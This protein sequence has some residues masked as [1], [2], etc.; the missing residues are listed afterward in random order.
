MPSSAL[1]NSLPRSGLPRRSSGSGPEGRGLS[2]RE[3]RGGLG[4]GAEGCKEQICQ[5]LKLKPT[6]SPE[7]CLPPPPPRKLLAFI[8]PSFQGGKPCH[9]QNK[10]PIAQELPGRPQRGPGGR[11]WHFINKKPEPDFL[12]VRPG[13]SIWAAS[14]AGRCAQLSFPGQLGLLWPGRLPGG[15][16]RCCLLGSSGRAW[17]GRPVATESQGIPAPW[18]SL[19]WPGQGLGVSG[20]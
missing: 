4:L 13:P 14:I 11:S 1:E 12:E 10:T 19:G 5:T 17:G 18:G 6:T 8:T 20:S 7:G 3:R 2:Q 15:P 9:L 16:A